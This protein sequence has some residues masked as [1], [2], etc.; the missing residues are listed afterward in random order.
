M[1]GDNSNHDNANAAARLE[2]ELLVL[3]NAA[4]TLSLALKD[5]LFELDLE[6]RKKSDVQTISVLEK[7]RHPTL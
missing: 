7:F 4:V 2:S 6:Q 3:R 5:I 1:H